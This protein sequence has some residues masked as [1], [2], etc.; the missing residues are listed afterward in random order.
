M[1]TFTLSAC[2]AEAESE[3]WFACIED[4]QPS[5]SPKTICSS[6]QASLSSLN[7]FCSHFLVDFNAIF[8]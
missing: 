1:R 5:I 8:Y 3:G 7:N 4:R 6:Q 2:Q